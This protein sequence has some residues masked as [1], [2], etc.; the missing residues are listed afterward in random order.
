M[1]R[2]F[3][4]F[5]STALAVASLMT[6]A[7]AFATSGTE[8]ALDSTNEVTEASA[9]V[10]TGAA[11]T[12]DVE[13]FAA[14]VQLVKDIDYTLDYE[15]NIHVGQATI[16]VNFQGNYTGTR[17][18]TFNIIARTLSQD[19]VVISGISE[20]PYPYTGNPIE[21]HPTITLKDGTE[22]VEGTDYELSYEDNTDNGTAKVIVEFKGDYA[23][24]AEA[25][26]TIGSQEI[27]TEGIIISDIPNQT[28]TG[29]PIEP[30]PSS[31]RYGSITF[32]EG[33]DYD[34]SYENNVNVGTATLK[35]TLKGN[36]SGTK[37][38]DFQIV[39]KP[40][41]SNIQSGDPQDG[42]VENG[43]VRVAN[44]ADQTF[45]GSA[46]TPK[47]AVKL[48]DTTLVE[49]TDF[50][51]SYENNI[52]AGTATLTVTF[53]GNYS[54]SGSVTFTINPKTVTET[55][56]RISGIAD[57]TFTGSA[58]TPEPTVTD[59]ERVAGN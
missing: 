17:T 38:K 55:N 22:L 47:P 16:T 1:N 24:S 7:T 2:K 51:F 6:A 32:T 5:V 58:I 35:V 15:N 54:G 25:E 4:T 50:D 48:G 31:V 11:I 37:T 57:Q 46:I 33:V 30:H 59:I 41:D 27:D 20:D 12:P 13:M 56:V 45:T 10:F 53:K 8:V 42:D 28:Y 23:G 52:N 3:N 39:A 19:D 18:V 36:Y 9:S 21:P 44:I 14:G 49:G 43:I 34:L 40:I 26:F 29:S